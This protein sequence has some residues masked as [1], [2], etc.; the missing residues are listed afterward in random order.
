M[1][2]SPPCWF[3]ESGVVGEVVM[4]VFA[5]QISLIDWLNDDIDGDELDEDSDG[6]DVTTTTTLAWL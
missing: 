5:S 3:K 2:Q 4:Q 6:D 1:L